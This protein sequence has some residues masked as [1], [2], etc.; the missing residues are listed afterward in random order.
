[1]VSSRMRALP[2]AARKST[3]NAVPPSRETTVKDPPKF[4][5]IELR[6][7]D[8]ILPPADTSVRL[9]NNK[10]F[11]SLIRENTGLYCKQASQTDHRF[12]AAT[13]LRQ[14]EAKGGRLLVA[15]EWPSWEG[16]G[17]TCSTFDQAVEG[18]LKLF[19][20]EKQ[21]FQRPSEASLKKPADSETVEDA[22]GTDVVLP[23][24]G[25]N[26]F[27]TNNPNFNQ[28][29]FGKAESYTCFVNTSADDRIVRRIVK[30]VEK[31]GGRF[32][33]ADTTNKSWR[34]LSPADVS[35]G[36]H[37]LLALVQLMNEKNTRQLTKPKTK[38]VAL[39][40]TRP[41]KKSRTETTNS[42]YPQPLGAIPVNSH[43][44]PPAGYPHMP[45]YGF[46]YN[47]LIPMPVPPPQ[48]NNYYQPVPAPGIQEKEEPSSQPTK[49]VYAP[50][51]AIQEKKPSSLPAKPSHVP[52]PAIQETKAQPAE[53]HN[54]E[55][56]EEKP[57]SKHPEYVYSTNRYD[58][59]IDLFCD[60]E[61]YASFQSGDWNLQ[62]V[63]LPYYDDYFAGRPLVRLASMIAANVQR[64]GGRFLKRVPFK[65]SRCWVQ[66]SKTERNE[67]IKRVLL[68]LRKAAS[69]TNVNWKKSYASLIMKS[70]ER[71]HASQESVDS[72]VPNSPPARNQQNFVNQEAQVQSQSSDSRK[73]SNESPPLFSQ[74]TIS[75]AKPETFS[76]A[77]QLALVR[78]SLMKENP[79]LQEYY[80]TYFDYNL[81]APDGHAQ[82][83]L[84]LSTNSEDDGPSSPASRN[85]GGT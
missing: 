33:M 1:M 7:D 72:V 20:H 3:A 25:H 53:L 39:P 37:R 77:N 57:E 68:N 27:V 36:V 8:V 51:P 14:L 28:L 47:P 69:S 80:G 15:T 52:A 24:L 23:P 32:L 16:R 45:F 67:H 55:S 6:P 82:D 19:E 83:F 44:M 34:L 40:A 85:K 84:W 41:P 43:P 29:I 4:V 62:L 9:T 38:P 5:V 11:N 13:V 61:Q 76:N 58:V 78:D 22:F 17:W 48:P 18:I 35:Y 2:L 79:S 30:T 74:R 60:E 12:I 75:A 56:V 64:K 59:L 54:H 81:F 50:A 73:L 49:P 63:I 71:L 10:Y 46:M 21:Y 26:N 65:N 70:L 66:A 31:W 42:Q